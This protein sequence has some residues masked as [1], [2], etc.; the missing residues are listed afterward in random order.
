MTARF[1]PVMALAF[2]HTRRHIRRRMIS[3]LVSYWG[4][5]GRAC[6]LGMGQSLRGGRVCALGLGLS[7]LPE[8]LWSRRFQTYRVGLDPAVPPPYPEAG[9]PHVSGLDP[10]VISRSPFLTTPPPSLRGNRDGGVRTVLNRSQGASSPLQYTIG[11]TR[12][13]PMASPSFPM[14]PPH[15]MSPVT[16]FLPF[17]KARDSVI[18]LALTILENRDGILGRR[19]LYL[20]EPS[21]WSFLEIV[22]RGRQ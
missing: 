1:R 2:R 10:L 20:S 3:C 7:M 11:E 19:V 15:P 12:T 21:L 13:Q 22:L 6:G 14:T 4:P 18:S 17:H 16:T 8:V 5:R 9:T